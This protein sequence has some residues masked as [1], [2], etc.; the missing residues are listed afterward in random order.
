MAWSSFQRTADSENRPRGRSFLSSFFFFGIHHRYDRD[1]AFSF[2]S[3]RH[4][5]RPIFLLF[6]SIKCHV[7][8]VAAFVAS[9]TGDLGS[10]AA[11]QTLWLF[12]ISLSAFWQVFC[13]SHIVFVFYSLSRSTAAKAYFPRHQLIII[14][15]APCRQAKLSFYFFFFF[16]AVFQAA[17]VSHIKRSTHCVPDSV[18]LELSAATIYR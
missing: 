16:P 1:K 14:L 15:Q 11:K 7:F 6:F 10:A 8:H 18:K 12:H 13:Q 4:T 5:I 17:P 3:Y 2:L 9:T